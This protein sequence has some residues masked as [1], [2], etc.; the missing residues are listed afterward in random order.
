[1]SDP[2]LELLSGKLPPS[3]SPT[4]KDASDYLTRLTSLSLNEIRTSEPAA[5]KAAQ[6][7]INLSIQSLSSRSYRQLI[8]ASAHLSPIPAAVAALQESVKSL[9]AALPE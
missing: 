6:H 5:I 4:D 3:I 9:Q 2:L 7:S 1:M 8:N